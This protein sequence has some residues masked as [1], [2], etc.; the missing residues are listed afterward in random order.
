MNQDQPQTYYGFYTQHPFWLESKPELSISSTIKLPFVLSEIQFASYQDEYHLVVCRDGLIQF[1][2]PHS[3]LSIQTYIQYLQTIYLLLNSHIFE[4]IRQNL[5]GFQELSTTDILSHTY[6]AQNIQAFQLDPE[7]IPV[8]YIYSTR[9]PRSFVAGLPWGDLFSNKHSDLAQLLLLNIQQD[10]RIQAREQRIISQTIF[11]SLNQS[12]KHIISNY[13]IVET[14]SGFFK[15][16]CEHYKGNKEICIILIWFELESLLLKYYRNKAK[17]YFTPS[18]IENQNEEV[19]VSQVLRVLRQKHML[20]KHTIEQI[21]SI[22]MLRNKIAHSRSEAHV[23]QNDVSLAVN[24]LKKLI[25][26]DFKISLYL[27]I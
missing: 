23:T 17:M 3:Q 4:T 22:R 5:L 8:N 2:K 25:L 16:L 6:T 21:H 19:S 7:N 18:E 15:A 14:L 27:N 24:V 12:L 10:P 20:D 26:Q 9:F 13:Q 1:C 11:Q